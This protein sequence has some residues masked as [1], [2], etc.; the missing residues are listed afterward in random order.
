MIEVTSGSEESNDEEDGEHEEES[1]EE[2]DTE[3]EEENNGTDKNEEDDG[4]MSVSGCSGSDGEG[5]VESDD[6]RS[7]TEMTA[8]DPYVG[9]G[10][11]AVRLL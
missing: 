6:D 4:V 2:E 8:S 5:M 9:R 3:N 1:E 7:D 11:T 10:C